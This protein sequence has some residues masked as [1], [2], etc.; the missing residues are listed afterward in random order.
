MG[1]FF[2]T[3]SVALIE[4]L[5]LEEEY[6]NSDKLQT[7]MEAGFQQVRS[8]ISIQSHDFMSGF[9]SERAKLLDRSAALLSDAV[10]LRTTVLDEQPIHLQCL[11]QKQRHQL[12]IQNHSRH[13][14]EDFYNVNAVIMVWSLPMSKVSQRHHHHPLKKELCYLI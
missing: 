10:R 2:Y 4:D 6:D 13:T 7:E 12:H 3:N 8:V 1:V 11:K 5:P 14:I 9:F